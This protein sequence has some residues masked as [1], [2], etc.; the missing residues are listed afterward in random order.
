MKFKAKIFVTLSPSV[1]DPAGTAVKS[2]LD[3][4]GDDRQVESVRIGKYIETIF[5]TEDRELAIAYVHLACD[6]LLV[7]P[8]IETYTFEINP[9]ETE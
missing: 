7:N 1:L 4:I 5:N 2:A 8:V 9:C 6:R 3:Q